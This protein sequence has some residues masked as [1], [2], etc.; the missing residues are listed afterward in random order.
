MD[1]SSWSEIIKQ[2]GFNGALV[3]AYTGIGSR[4]LTRLLESFDNIHKE[5]EE[6]TKILNQLLG[7][8]KKNGNTD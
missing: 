1:V 2:V 8:T 6:H 7:A 5:M 4:F 3:L